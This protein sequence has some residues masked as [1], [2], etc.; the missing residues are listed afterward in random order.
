M[1]SSGRPVSLG[2]MVAGVL[3]LLVGLACAGF[4]VVSLA[5]QIPFWLGRRA[6]AEVVDHWTEWVGED[7]Q[8]Q[9]IYH[10]FIRYHYTTPDGETVSQISRL[11]GQEWV[12]SDVGNQV[13]ILY[14]PLHPDRIRL[15]Y[16]RFM[17][18]YA[19]CGL[20]IAIVAG[21]GLV[22]GWR[23]IRPAF[24]KLKR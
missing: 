18:L 3:L 11:S 21:V 2:E 13:A 23:F 16:R 17:P 1:F 24:V 10:Y 14:S 6:M 20:P 5:D 19:G 7:S 12:A 8:G 4:L 15:D 9:R 22:F